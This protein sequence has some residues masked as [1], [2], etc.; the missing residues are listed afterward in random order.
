MERR[1]KVVETKGGKQKIGSKLRRRIARQDNN[2]P[3]L[4]E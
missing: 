4:M 1:V 3:R 2:T